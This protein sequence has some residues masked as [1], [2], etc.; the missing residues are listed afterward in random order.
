MCLSALVPAV[1]DT[2]P[3][4]YVINS[5]RTCICNVHV[6][7][8]PCQ[9]TVSA[10]FVIVRR[11]EVFYCFSFTGKKPAVFR[12]VGVMPR[13]LSG[14][15]L[16]FVPFAPWDSGLGRSRPMRIPVFLEILSISP[17]ISIRSSRLA[18]IF[19]ISG[20]RIFF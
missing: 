17:I 3:F 4:H 7:Y 14:P 16:P 11:T 5:C 2:V 12:N 6:N 15:H 9:I 18:F 20:Q 19:P 1:Y 8:V 10:E 13:F